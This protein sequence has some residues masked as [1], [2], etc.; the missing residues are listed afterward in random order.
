VIRLRYADWITQLDEK[1]EIIHEGRPEE[2]LEPLQDGHDME[3]E[4]E[5]KLEVLAKT[6]LATAV[7][8]LEEEEDEMRRLGDSTIYLFYAKA[9]GRAKLVSL[10]ICMTIFASC[11]SFP[12]KPTLSRY[13]VIELSL[14]IYSS[15]DWMVG[16]CQGPPRQPWEVARCLCCT[17]IW[18]YYLGWFRNLVCIVVKISTER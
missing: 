16:W 6:Q 7:E 14:I 3:P 9:A 17:W 12:S 2:M 10:A 4:Y 18:S 11:Q 8:P 13:A 15:V 5:D 1:D